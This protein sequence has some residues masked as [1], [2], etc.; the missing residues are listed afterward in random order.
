MKIF[1]L[2]WEVEKSP[3]SPVDGMVSHFKIESIG[4]Y[5]VVWWSGNYSEI[6]GAYPEKS[7][8]SLKLV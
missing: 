5:F 2:R 6:I 8:M 7:E 1:W 3:M 4:K